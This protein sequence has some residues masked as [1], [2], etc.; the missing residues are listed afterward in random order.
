MRKSKFVI[1]T[2]AVIPQITC[3]DAP[4]VCHVGEPRLLESVASVHPIPA[5]PWSDSKPV[6]W[7]GASVHGP[8]CG[9]EERKLKHEK[10]KNRELD[11][12]NREISIQCCIIKGFILYT[13]NL[14]EN[15]S[16]KRKEALKLY[17][18]PH[19]LSMLYNIMYVCTT[20]NS[21]HFVQFTHTH[22]SLACRWE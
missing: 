16:A 20:H 9:R 19:T 10:I 8:L 18:T 2:H 5:I 13:H 11:R 14:F 17:L 3:S 1:F 21:T 6:G 7:E 4:L 15:Q 22:L 12:Y